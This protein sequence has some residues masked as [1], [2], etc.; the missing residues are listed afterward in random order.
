MY[1]KVSVT[2]TT[3]LVIAAILTVSWSALQRSYAQSDFANTIL[4]IHN[5]ER[6]AVK[7]PDLTWSDSLAADAKKWAEHL[8][9]LPP[10]PS[11]SSGWN[12]C[13]GGAPD[14]VHGSTGEN[15]WAGGA[16]YYSTADMVKSWASEKSN[17][18]GAPLSN[19]DFAPGVPMVGH[20]TQMVWKNTRDVGCATAIGNQGKFEFL[21]CRYSPP[22]NTLGQTPY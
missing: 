20:Y 21:V 8:A 22:G 3:T 1:K 19:A 17:Y 6:A 15:L 5:D 11:S 10:K 18:H 16:N 2:I 9:S 13:C 14:L 7:V 12:Q 4:K